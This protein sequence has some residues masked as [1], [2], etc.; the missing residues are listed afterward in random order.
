MSLLW[1]IPVMIV[2]LLL[3]GFFSGS[4]IALV[5]TDKIKLRHRAKQGHR[6][7]RLVAEALRHPE[8]ILATTLVGTN[9]ATVVLTTLATLLMVSASGTQAGDLYAVV[10]FTPLLL[11]LGEIVPK[12]I[13]QQKADTIAPVAIYALR[14]FSWLFWP[15]VLLFSAVSG[16]AARAVGRRGTAGHLFPVRDQL[17]HVMDMA[18]R[19]SDTGVF[20]RFRI[21][22]AIRFADST[23]GEE[24]TPVGDIVGLESTAT[25]QEAIALVRRTG[26][27]HLP[28]FEGHMGNVVAIASLTMWDLLDPGTASRPLSDFVRPAHYVTPVQPLDEVRRLL[29]DREDQLAIVVDEFGSAVGM[30]TLGDVMAAVVGDIDTGLDFEGFVPRP[31]PAWHALG[32]DVYLLD[33]RLPISEL[34]DLL[35]VDLASTEYHTVAGLVMSHLRHLA[36]Q[37]ESV[38]IRGLRFTVVD[39]T[40][41]SVGRVRVERAER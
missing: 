11:V 2:L 34:S 1:M 9:I 16:A 30:V 25:V 27:T 10:V 38:V 26:Y 12:S 7:S 24:M 5:S 22:R 31:M 18:E 13:Y 15:I 14:F 20:D 35:G 3:K 21:E 41:R 29:R 6:G 28:V 40:E 19:T 36:Q 23:V 4:E 37:G 8:R 33:G 17:R 32:E 39:A